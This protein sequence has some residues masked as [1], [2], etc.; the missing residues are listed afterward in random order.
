MT[1]GDPTAE[2]AADL[3][4]SLLVS[5]RVLRSRTSSEEISASQFSVLAYLQREGDATPGVLADFERV[6]PPVMTRMLR[7]LEDAGHV[8]RSAHPRDGRQVLVTLTDQGR[9]LVETGRAERDAWLRSRIATADPED[10]EILRRAAQVL[11]ELLV[12]HRD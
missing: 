11:R 10:R 9:R 8:T 1:A 5:S 7:R 3:R 6:T 2:L 4:R 12:E